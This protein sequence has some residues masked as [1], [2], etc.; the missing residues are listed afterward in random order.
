MGS[1]LGWCPV[2]CWTPVQLKG[3]RCRPGKRQGMRRVGGKSEE[4]GVERGK[5]RLRGKR[6]VT[7][8]KNL[9]KQRVKGTMANSV[10]LTGK[11]EKDGIFMKVRR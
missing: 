8:G 1:M 7:W 3:K 4:T 2:Q 5:K 11:K 10:K 6:K 9:G